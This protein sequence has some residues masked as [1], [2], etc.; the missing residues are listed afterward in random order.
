MMKIE[1]EEQLRQIF[2]VLNKKKGC[3]KSSGDENEDKLMPWYEEMGS[4]FEEFIEWTDYDDEYPEA[5][6]ESIED[7]LDEMGVDIDD[8]E[9]VEEYLEDCT[10]YREN[11]KYYMTISGE[12]DSFNSM[13][14]IFDIVF[15]SEPM[16]VYFDFLV[17]EYLDEMIEFAN[18]FFK[19]NGVPEAL[20]DIIS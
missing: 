15:S 9:E 13:R 16:S 11:S 3:Y 6:Y 18:K 8:D 5:I 17:E 14:E 2:E 1:N 12:V 10:E 4:Y 20:T 19:E 7:Y